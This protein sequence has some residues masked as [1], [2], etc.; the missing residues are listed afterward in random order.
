M[1]AVTSLPEVEVYQ[2]TQPLAPDGQYHQH[3]IYGLAN[4]MMHSYFRVAKLYGYRV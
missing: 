3:P 4:E 2:D 1:Q